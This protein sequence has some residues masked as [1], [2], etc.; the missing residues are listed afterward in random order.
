M[1]LLLNE[2]TFEGQFTSKEDFIQTAL[3]NLNEILH[4]LEGFGHILLKKQDVMYTKITKSETLSDLMLSPP[5]IYKNEIRRFSLSLLKLANEPFWEDSMLQDPDIAY[6]WKSEDIWGSSLAES[7]ERDKVVLSI[8]NS[9][10]EEP[11]L[12][13]FRQNERIEIANILKPKELLEYLWTKNLISFGEYVKN[14]FS[15][16]KLDFSKFID[17]R[18][19]QVIQ[20][21]E[22]FLFIDAFRKFNELSWEEIGRDGGFQYKDFNGTLSGFSSQNINLKKFRASQKIRCHG[23]RDG[24]RFYVL[25]LEVD[26]NLSDNG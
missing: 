10:F 21:S 18:N 13:V 16:G 12:S 25:F 15:T 14:R 23:Y 8:Q 24:K 3:A 17:D 11:I 5:S 20:S 19:F 4:E 2:L 26:H 22:Q 9:R 7:C 1:E 6:I